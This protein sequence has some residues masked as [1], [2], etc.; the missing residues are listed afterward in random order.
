MVK[1]AK[2]GGRAGAALAALLLPVAG[3]GAQRYLLQAEDHE[4]AVRGGARRLPLRAIDEERGRPVLVRARR[5]Q[6]VPW[7]PAGELRRVRPRHPSGYLIGGAITLAVGGA[8]MGG[9]FG[10]WASIASSCSME[11]GACGGGWLAEPIMLSFGVGHAIVGAV[12]L[13]VGAGRWSPEV[14]PAPSPRPAEP[15][16]PPKP[17]DPAR[18]RGD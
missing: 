18:E 6:L 2:I 5:L 1:R 17:I 11:G 15:A 8:L 14:R 9:A 4:L 12:L 10:S 13:G 7:T 3:C 16:E